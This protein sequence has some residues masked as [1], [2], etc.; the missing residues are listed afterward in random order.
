MKKANTSTGAMLFG[1]AC[2]VVVMGGYVANIVKLIGMLNGS[3]TAMFVAR[4]I[5]LFVPPVGS[6]MGFM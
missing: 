2:V 4:A 5:G 1:I 6:V 3:V